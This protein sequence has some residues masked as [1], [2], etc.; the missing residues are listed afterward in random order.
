M[1]DRDFSEQLAG[2]SL[3]TAHILYRMPDHPSLL[4]SY[5]WQEYDLHPRFPKLR[6]FLEFWSKNLDGKLFR[7]M[8]AHKA[9][10]APAEIAAV[11]T[12]LRLH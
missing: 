7:V 5:I 3:T 10:I 9:L 1:V 6:S 4:Q 11:S 12:E 2:F 8:V